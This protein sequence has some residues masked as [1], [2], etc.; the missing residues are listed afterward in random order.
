MAPSLEFLEAIK[1]SSWALAIICITLAIKLVFWPITAKT[2]RAMKK[3]AAVNAKMMPEITKIRERYKNDY[4]K[5]NMKMMETYKKYGVNPLSQV[6]GCLPMLI[7]IPIFFGFFTMLRSAVELRGAEFLWAS[8]L[9]SPDTI[10]TL[11]GFPINIMPLL[12]TATMFFQMR[13]QPPSPGMDPTQ[14]AMMKYMPLMFVVFFYSASSGLCLYWTVQNVLT[15][16]QTKLTKVDPE[17]GDKGNTQ[18]EVIPPN[19]KRKRT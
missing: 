19:K 8:D 10:A 9:S 2:T 5:M 11:A 18:V 14:Q 17:A 3:M 1:I 15:I 16:I 6:G 12:M 13:L 7:Q 4:Q